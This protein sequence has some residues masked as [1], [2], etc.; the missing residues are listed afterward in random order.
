MSTTSGNNAKLLAEKLSDKQIKMGYRD[1]T[2]THFDNFKKTYRHLHKRARTCGVKMTEYSRRK[3]RR[4]LKSAQ[5][6]KQQTD[7]TIADIDP[8]KKKVYIEK[9]KEVDAKFEAE[10]NALKKQYKKDKKMLRNQSIKL[11]LPATKIAP[12]V[13]YVVETLEE[14]LAEEEKDEDEEYY[15]INDNS[16]SESVSDSDEEQDESSE[17]EPKRKPNKDDDNDKLSYSI[18]S[19][20]GSGI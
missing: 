3:K 8:E 1:I 18:M 12:E 10:I 2:N 7:R 19:S 13:N 15:G 14:Q 9:V 20:W 6:V 5:Q 11:G 16:D 4:L 17:P